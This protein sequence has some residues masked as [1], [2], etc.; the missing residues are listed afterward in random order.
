MSSI[1]LSWALGKASQGTKG[2][3][4]GGGGG[5]GAVQYIFVFTRSNILTG[6]KKK[7]LQQKTHQLL[8]G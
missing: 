2:V 4:G 3:Y 5:R 8:H 7:D 6:K 1:T